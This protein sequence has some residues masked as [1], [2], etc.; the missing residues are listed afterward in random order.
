MF[1]IKMAGLFIRIRNRFPYVENQCRDWRVNLEDA[2]P[3]FEVEA[4]VDEI[5]Q[6][7]AN[8]QFSR[9]YCESI[10][11]YRLIAQK[12]WL[13]DAF[14]F[15]ASVVSV[16]GQGYA[17]TAK[18]GVG[19]ST[20]TRYWLE[21]FGDRAC[22]VN[23]DKPI[24]RYIDGKFYAYGTPWRGKENWGSNM[25]VPLKA[26][27]FLMRGSVSKIRPATQD[28]VIRYLFHQVLMPDDET[29]MNEFMDLMEHFMQEVPFYVL[30]CTMDPKSAEIAYDGIAKSLIV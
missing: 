4:S 24:V 20:H 3:D 17:F 28:D 1:D 16:E 23:G 27:S 2:E 5:R 12:L 25:S 7:L 11:I 30:E 15:H 14:V 13:Y 29:E 6:E 19:K 26:C 10:C 8:G 22:V 21:V 18:S 9:G